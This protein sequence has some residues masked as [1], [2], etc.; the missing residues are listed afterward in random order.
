M[1]ERANV[2]NASRRLMIE[3]VT[4]RKHLVFNL[5]E[6]NAFRKSEQGNA[7]EFPIPRISVPFVV[8]PYF[9]VLEVILFRA[10]RY[11]VLL[12][13]RI[14]GLFAVEPRNSLLIISNLAV[15]PEARRHGIGVY[16]LDQICRMGAELGLKSLRLRVLKKNRPAQRLYVKYGF[17]KK[18][19][20]QF[21]LKLEKRLRNH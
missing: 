16:M 10:R 6:F 14:V 20:S 4:L 12:D 11:F 3:R 15:V 5:Y 1:T 2:N 21:S 7:F 17:V 18:S 13:N 8:V 19:E 9:A